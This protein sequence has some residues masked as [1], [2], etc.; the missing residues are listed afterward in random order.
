M[1]ALEAQ[2]VNSGG[3]Q[4]GDQGG[5]SGGGDDWRLA[6]KPAHP[7][8]GPMRQG[9]PV[10]RGCGQLADGPYTQLVCVGGR[11]APNP[12]GGE[13]MARRPIGVGLAMGSCGLAGPASKCGGWG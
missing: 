7:D 1:Y 5:E 3:V 13:G 4:A 11:G 6:G 8:Q 2:C 9:Q 10:G 12:G